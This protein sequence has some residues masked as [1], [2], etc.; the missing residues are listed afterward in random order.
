MFAP[1]P[2]T[3][4]PVI[5][6]FICLGLVDSALRFG[7]LPAV[8]SVCNPGIGLGIALPGAVL[9]TVVPLILGI[10]LSRSLMRPYGTENLAWGAIFI[11]GATNA[12]DRLVHGCV[13]DYLSLPFFPSFNLADI[14]VFLGVV[15]LALSF[16]GMLPQSK[17][18]AS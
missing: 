3:A 9:W 15:T 6:L 12:I 5:G 8:F 14:M 7:P 2:E 18:Y 1:S 11:G 17:P 13:M 16:L 10:V 4:K